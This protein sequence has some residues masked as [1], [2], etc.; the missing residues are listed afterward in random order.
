MITR[1]RVA[2]ILKMAL[3]LTAGLSS[4]L[5]MSTVDL[6]M[7]GRLGNSA[8]AAVGLAGFSFS[9]I[10]AFVSGI[11]P[12]VQGVVAR[13]SGEG[14]A[15]AKCLPLNGGLLLVLAIGVPLSILCYWLTPW[16][17][18][19]I[20]SDPQVAQQGVPYLRVLVLGMVAKGMDSAFEGYWMGIGRTKVYML[21]VVF[22]NALHIVLNYILIF[23]HFGAPALGATGAGIAS[24]LSVCVS[25]VIYAVITYVSYR[26]EGFLSARPES[27]LVIRMVQIGLPAM[28]EGAFFSLGFVAYYWI[29]GRVGTPALAATNVLVRVS[30]LYVLFAQALGMTSATLV[31]K[32]LGEGDPDGASQWGWDIAKITV[33]WITL[34][35]VPLVLFPHACLGIFLDD[36]ATIAVAT[37]PTQLTGAFTGIVSLIYIFATTLVSLGDGKRVLIVSFSTQWA[38]FL[39]AVWIVGMIL[40]GG[41]LGI[42]LVETA[43]GLIAT[44]LITGIWSDGRWKKIRV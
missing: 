28:F 15:A 41:L 13:R 38:L 9:L 25:T 33:A 32:T 12:A 39:P 37:I 11:A 35:G 6:A 2:T 14:S 36:P 22:V 31:A 30:L 34:L 20:S 8:V 29:V 44:A 40:N 24:T 19:V 3:P 16:F 10:S 4:S 42:S 23:G 7:V 27:A 21:N 5:I 17:F 43:Y 26:K 18:S 1:D